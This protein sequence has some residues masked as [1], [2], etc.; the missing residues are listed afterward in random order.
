[1]LFIV[2]FTDQNYVT[3]FGNCEDRISFRREDVL[4]LSEIE[5]PVKSNHQGQISTPGWGFQSEAI[6]QTRRRNRAVLIKV[7]GEIP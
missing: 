5:D 2:N 6:D 7:T 4:Q 3:N 1:M